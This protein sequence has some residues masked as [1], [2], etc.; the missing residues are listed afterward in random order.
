MFWYK[1]KDNISLYGLIMVCHCDKLSSFTLLLL[2]SS[3]YLANMEKV[4][5]QKS[6]YKSLLHAE[7]VEEHQRRKMDPNTLEPLFTSLTPT[8]SG[9]I[10]YILYSGKL[11]FLPSSNSWTYYSSH[12]SIS[13]FTLLG[14]FCTILYDV[15]TLHTLLANYTA[16]YCKMLCLF[17]V[18]KFLQFLSLSYRI[19]SDD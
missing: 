14:W 3:R 15:V 1:I 19:P 13:L 16:S 11:N 12:I 10:D 5:L 7:G 9:T 18:A 8:F 4:Y 17:V 6:A 2:S